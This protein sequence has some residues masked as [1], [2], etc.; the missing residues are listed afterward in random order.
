MSMKTF[1]ICNKNYTP[2]CSLN[3][4]DDFLVNIDYQVTENNSK[5]GLNVVLHDNNQN[6]I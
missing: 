2:I 4:D 1:I 3:V 6:I 5:I